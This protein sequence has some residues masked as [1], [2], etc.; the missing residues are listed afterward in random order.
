M[1]CAR[2]VIAAASMAAAV[3][4]Q[5]GT[6][7]AAPASQIS[8]KRLVA[9]TYQQGLLSEDDAAA[10]LVVAGSTPEVQ[11]IAG[12]AWRPSLCG[13]SLTGSDSG[14]A[15]RTVQYAPSGDVFLAN[16]VVA[17]DSSK[18]AQRLVTGAESIVKACTAPYSLG[19]LTAT[20]AR[21]PAI[22]K[23][24]EQRT[25]DAGTL[26]LGNGRT[27]N[28]ADILVR[29][30]Q[31]V[32]LT[33][34]GSVAP[35]TPEIVKSVAKAMDNRLKK[36]QKAAS[37]EP[38]QSSS[39]ASKVR[40]CSDVFARGAGSRIWRRAPGA[41][42]LLLRTRPRGRGRRR[43]LLPRGRRG[44]EHLH[45]ARKRRARRRQ[46]CSRRAVPHEPEPVRPSDGEH[47]RT[48]PRR[49]DVQHHAARRRRAQGSKAAA[50]ERRI[51]RDEPIH[52]EVSRD[53][54]GT[55]RRRADRRGTRVSRCARAISGTP[56][57]R[58]GSLQV[59]ARSRLQPANPVTPASVSFW[60][61]TDTSTKASKP[62]SC[63]VSIS[64]SRPHSCRIMPARAAV[65]R[66][67][68]H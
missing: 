41:G 24:G 65:S 52:F 53:V 68:G 20:P 2:T 45:P 64:S 34:M 50:H 3:L 67:R 66:T 19:S 27:A 40:S 55:S 37:K 62:R 26:D 35:I 29:D 56:R 13:R 10:F 31:F 4:V 44:T 46:G 22:P 11:P 59:R 36:L 7:H 48:H 25:G 30:G 33:V 5:T 23:V 58:S 17:F 43:R 16:T 9:L 28:S 32:D 39:A 49:R 15:G 18:N 57:S 6:T 47:L 12:G 1:G 61:A 21:A 8:E 14:I 54:G 38:Q 63:A 42:G 51:N 60:T